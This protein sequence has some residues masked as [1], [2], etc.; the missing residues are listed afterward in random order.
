MRTIFLYPLTVFWFGFCHAFLQAQSCQING[1]VTLCQNAEITYTLTVSG[2]SPGYTADWTA[3]GGVV[4]G[5]SNTE[6]LVAWPSEGASALE[7]SVTD[8]LGHSTQCVLDVNVNP[9][10]IGVDLYNS[11]RCLPEPVL[12]SVTGGCPSCTY[13]WT[14]QGLPGA[15]LNAQ[16][17]TA[18]IVG[19]DPGSGVYCVTVTNGFGCSASDCADITFL[20]PSPLPVTVTGASPNGPNTWQV[21]PNQPVIFSTEEFKSLIW[22]I[23]ADNGDTWNLYGDEIT[24]EFLPPGPNTYTVSASFQDENQGCF[25]IPDQIV[26]VLNETPVVISCPSVVCEGEEVTYTVPPGCTSNGTDFW[27][28]S[29]QGTIIG[30]PTATAVTV[31]WA[32]DPTDPEGT[33]IY[34][35]ICPGQCP[36][37]SVVEVPIIP[38]QGSIAGPSIICGASGFW[39]TA[40]YNGG[41]YHW[42]YTPSDAPGVSESNG[43]TGTSYGLNFTTG[44]SGVITIQM[45][46]SHPI[47]GCSYTATKEVEYNSFQISGPSPICAVDV[48]EAHT[49]T[50]I[51]NASGTVTWT[52][53]NGA[54]VVAS[55]TSNS[56]PH[57]FTIPGGV[58]EPNKNY[59]LFAM[60]VSGCE[61][62]MTIN[63]RPV[64]NTQII[65][66][67][68]VCAGINVQYNKVGFGSQYIWTIEKENQAPYTKTGFP[69]TENWPEG[70]HLLSLQ[71]ISGA[72]TSQVNTIHIT[73][74]QGAAPLQITGDEAP[75]AD[76]VAQYSVQ[77]ND[78]TNY[79]WSIQNLDGSPSNIGSVIAGQGTPQVSI[80]WLGVSAP[81][82]VVL[83]LNATVCGQPASTQVPITIT[84]FDLT[85]S[86]APICEGDNAILNTNASTGAVFTAWVDGLQA[87]NSNT[88]KPIPAN[89]LGS[90]THQITLSVL[91]PNGCLGLYS[92]TASL[93][94]TPNPVIKINLSDPLPCP[95]GTPFTRELVAVPYTNAC[96]YTWY[97]NSSIVG[98][99][100]TLTINAPG[101]YS[102]Q[103]QCGNCP[104][105]TATREVK[106]ECRECCE[107]DLEGNDV[108]VTMLKYGLSTDQCGLLQF[109][110]IIQPFN[111][112]Y[113]PTWVI[114]LP[115]GLLAQ[116]PIFT[117]NNG[118]V[119]GAY[120]TNQIGIHRVYLVAQERWED[121]Q[122]VAVDLYGQKVIFEDF[123]AFEAAGPENFVSY[124]VV[125][126]GNPAYCP[127]ADYRTIVVPFLAKF[128]HNLS[129]NPDNSF[130]L[131]AY[132]AS[133]YFPGV[134][135]SVSWSTSDFGTPLTLHDLAGGSDIDLCM[136]LTDNATGYQ[137]SYCQTISLPAQPQLGI[138]IS[139]GATQLCVAQA[140]QFSPVVYPP[141]ASVNITSYHWDFGDG[142]FS[143]LA[144]PTKTYAAAGSYPVT[145]SATTSYGC[146]F[147]LTIT[148]QV[149]GGPAPDGL[150]D[151][152][153]MDC[154]A[155]Y[156]LSFHQTSGNPVQSYLWDPNA[157]TPFIVAIVGGT[158]ALTVTDGFGCTFAPQPFLMED[159]AF[160]EGINIDSQCGQTSISIS[161]TNPA[162]TYEWTIDPDVPGLSEPFTGSTLDINSPTE[163]SYKVVIN[164]LQNGHI[165]TS[166]TLNAAALPT[167]PAPQILSETYCEGEHYFVRLTAANIP[168]DVQF[169]WNT[170]NGY[171]PGHPT[172]ILA[173]GGGIYTLTY[174]A[175]NGCAQTSSITLP[176]F[177]D[178]STFLSGCYDC[179]ILDNGPVFLHGIPGSFDHWEWIIDGV[180]TFSGDGT[181]NDLELNN[182]YHEIILC[183]EV[184]DCHLCSD[185]FCLINCNPEPCRP[186]VPTFRRI[187]CLDATPDGD[188]SLTRYFIHWDFPSD[189]VLRPCNFTPP[190]ITLAGSA[191]QMGTFLSD[192]FQF[193]EIPGFWHFEGVFEINSQFM[194][195]DVCWEIPFCRISD[196]S[197]CGIA[198][199]CPGN[200]PVASC[201]NPNGPFEECDDMQIELLKVFCEDDPNTSIDHQLILHIEANV[202]ATSNTDNCPEFAIQITSISGD[203]LYPLSGQ[204]YNL[205]GPAVN[206]MHHISTDVE[207]GWASG[208]ANDILCLE[209]DLRQDY[210]CWPTDGK[211]CLARKCF[212]LTS[213]Q[214]PEHTGPELLNVGFTAVCNKEQSKDAT[215]VY[216]VT[217]S[218][219]FP[220]NPVGFSLTPMNGNIQNLVLGGNTASFQY[221]TT[222]GNLLFFATV[223]NNGNTY[224]IQRLLEDCG[225]IRGGGKERSAAETITDERSLFL[226]PNPASDWVHVL[227]TGSAADALEV[228]DVHG[229]MIR[230]SAAGEHQGNLLIPTGNWAPGMYF[231]ALK[232]PQGRTLVT[233]KLLVENK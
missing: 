45:E 231:F 134:N 19:T 115:N 1:P 166:V 58:L 85:L 172:S 163:T 80:H 214:C 175:E 171:P 194:P 125:F 33:V 112:A 20:E 210:D 88:L 157:T 193:E 217:I 212:D 87:F 15:T 114:E 188:P 41:S 2:M 63:V 21:C 34:N 37:P 67:T 228:Y 32:Y 204:L 64:I 130:D 93:T 117:H 190:V 126:S 198:T 200:F 113:N 207:L 99:G 183:V 124:Q 213:A 69:I 55:G 164:A 118:L 44:S 103:T 167:P 18:E 150:I 142:T 23:S 16:F 100:P 191:N 106:V 127:R 225:F 215:A 179:S 59:R 141:A 7:V 104:E 123:C 76:M 153:V 120:Q 197:P 169:Q 49:Y 138:D 211:I 139:N 13:N 25:A 136:T 42:S 72:C 202:P 132:D 149:S 203:L 68:V 223:T 226:Y 110:G 91:N 131:T 39:S 8:P 177:P 96:T 30:T 170:P 31:M 119:T 206:G 219:P 101:V 178:F 140:F 156:T 50:L 165:C 161:E 47:A 70:D 158:Y 160:P 143:S 6:A 78:G 205:G 24:F 109:S 102:V 36:A 43:N 40:T 83:V 218:F 66:P 233:R 135:A 60:S 92:E 65:G 108:S 14:L 54:T 107:Y 9:V 26:T 146:T 62:Q 38:V 187:Q 180:P 82:E 151:A 56:S 11:T 147:S 232:D 192:F 128:K 121:I 97:L 74:Y 28:I 35:G 189:G 152:V 209:V 27:T 129:C 17:N 95:E 5:E 3:V 196:G 75:C 181:I 185:A 81:V 89:L 77:P 184:G 155:S 12:V 84:P 221:S 230:Q 220:V 71:I 159:G 182:S 51:G 174:T 48:D 90:G 227:Y 168:P 186:P 224:Y 98:T 229:K 94:V 154:G 111:N 61:T 79:Q 22:T 173:D 137:C 105:R 148:V 116:I 162:F 86:V 176:G 133:S 201:I 216:N 195:A 4:L 199:V 57:T 222:V 144:E 208:Y 122:I 46:F 52:L 73:A 10:P 53:K 145:L 29:P